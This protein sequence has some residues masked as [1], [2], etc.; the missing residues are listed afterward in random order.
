MATH[1]RATAL[2]SQHE[3]RCPVF[4]SDLCSF[5]SFIYPLQTKFQPC[6]AWGCW[7]YAA[8]LTAAQAKL[9][10]GAKHTHFVQ[11]EHVTVPQVTV[12][13]LF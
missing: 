9:P 4:T 6:C 10:L 7:R 5:P 1:T 12:G 3:G 13:I 2:S 8:I 11:L